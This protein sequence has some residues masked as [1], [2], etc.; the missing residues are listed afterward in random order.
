MYIKRTNEQQKYNSIER[1][2]ELQNER[3]NERTNERN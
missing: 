2:N 1:N 3:T